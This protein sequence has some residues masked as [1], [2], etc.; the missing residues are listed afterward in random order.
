MRNIL[1]ISGMWPNKVELHNGIFVRELVDNQS[2]YGHR[3]YFAFV[4]SKVYRND[5]SLR[6]NLRMI[7]VHDPFEGHDV[8]WGWYPPTIKVS[9]LKSINL[10]FGRL[11]L[12]GRLAG[13]IKRHV[14]GLVHAHVPLIDGLLALEL[15]RKLN[16]PYVLH[17]HSGEDRKYCLEDS[18][19]RA[20]VTDVFRNASGVIANSSRTLT[21]VKRCIGQ[22]SGVAKVIP[23]GVEANELSVYSRQE[24]TNI[25]VVGVGNLT[26]QKRFDLLLQAM[27]K[28]RFQDRM[29]LTIIGEGPER[30]SLERLA[31]D[32]G[33]DPQVTFRGL[34]ANW[35]VRNEL[36]RHDIFVLP[37]VNEGFGVVYLEALA[38]GIPTIGVKGQ[39][40]EDIA[41]KGEGILLAEP[42]NIADLTAKI[43]F[44]IDQP[45][46]RLRMGQEG[47][48]VVRE[49]YSWPDIVREYDGLYDSI[50]RI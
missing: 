6:E 33:I 8:S 21:L 48:R 38:A 22:F 9:H 27:T 10:E 18:E 11:M 3:K 29:E 28:S 26:K 15:K 47:K 31:H 25:K 50:A 40:C 45:D 16:I 30:A 39:G 2:K 4:P 44:L 43:D 17:C 37:S 32:F 41:A 12:I 7:T 36:I 42:D 49:W 23:F 46:V 19:L 1:H 20:L 5:F 14:V 34:L 13:I 24:N 35:E